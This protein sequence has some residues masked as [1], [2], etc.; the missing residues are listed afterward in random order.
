M[1]SYRGNPNSDQNEYKKFKKG[2]NI[3]KIIEIN[4]IKNEIQQLYDTQNKDKIN[5]ADILNSQSNNESSKKDNYF[6]KN[7]VS[8]IENSSNYLNN[9]SKY[10]KSSNKIINY[11][12]K[13]D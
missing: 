1:N 3:L 13:I 10:K 4:S 12:N 8:N 2:K 11:S 7:W 5:E 6:N 9:T